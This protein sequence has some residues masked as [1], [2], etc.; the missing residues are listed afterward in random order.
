MVDLSELCPH[1]SP[2]R[3]LE[4][5]FESLLIELIK[6]AEKGKAQVTFPY[7]NAAIIKELERRGFDVVEYVDYGKDETLMSISWGED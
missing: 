5:Y 4:T 2:G 7:F 6:A 1:V 3:L